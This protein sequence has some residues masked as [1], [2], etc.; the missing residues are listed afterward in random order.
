MLNMNNILK[1]IAVGSISLGGQ[2]AHAISIDFNY[3]FDSNGFFSTQARKDVLESAA[4][5][6]ENRI[7]DNL[8]AINSSGSN[9]YNA[10]FTNPGTGLTQTINNFS[11]A[12]DTLIVYAGGKA[13]AGS[14]VGQGGP[15]GYSLSGSSA[16]LDSSITRGQGDGDGNRDDVRGAGAFD[17]APWGGS[18][19]FDTGATWYFDE[20]VSNVESFSGN[21]FYSIAI[22]ELAH[23]LGFGTSDSWDNQ[24]S[25][26]VFTGTNSGSVSLA[27][28]D[29]HWLNGT[30]SLVDGIV[31][32]ETSM[33][34]SITTGTRKYF[35]D[36]DL[37]ALQDVGWE[38]SAVPVPAAA[39]FFGSALLGLAG[40]RKK[41]G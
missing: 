3:A 7:N 39:Y 18:I 34:P 5:Y 27:S 8:T 16:F 15:G 2:Q 4:S 29:A 36:L 33:D 14:T 31:S 17:F 35:T 1:L 9:R 23:L 40:F 20:D 19:T 41:L 32:Q 37:A 26:G 10:I 6:F 30:S 38:V 13:L 28:G 24:V 21:D 25:G 22:H 12:A 11:V